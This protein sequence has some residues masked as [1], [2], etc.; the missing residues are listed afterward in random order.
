MLR[1]C[2]VAELSLRSW[3]NIQE[4]KFSPSGRFNVLSGDNGAGKS[5]ILEAIDYLTSLQSF[6]GARTEDL[7]TSG[8]EVSSLSARVEGDTLKHTL[9]IQL[10][11]KGRRSLVL[12][13]KR[14]SS[15]LS[16]KEV[17]PRVVFHPGELRLSSGA[18][19]G[20]RAFLDSILERSDASYASSLSTYQKALRSRNRLL[21]QTPDDLRSIRAYNPILAEHGARIG[22][23]RRL[24]VEELAT[25]AGESFAEIF[26]EGLALGVRYLARVEPT[27]ESMERAL[28][29]SLQKDIA[30]GYTVE[31]PQSDD[32]L[33][34]LEK[35]ASHSEAR[36]QASQ[37]QHRSIALSLKIAELRLLLKRTGKVPI[38]LLDD[39]TSE[40]DR[41]RNK[42]LF[43][44][45]QNL[46]GQVF[47][48]TTHPEFILLTENRRDY[49][50]EEGK[51][52]DED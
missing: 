4:L 41:R 10:P 31:G 22:M 17:F 24:L 25:I 15:L 20:R 3:R 40:L 28:H 2:F 49:T 43:G 36:R 19:D 6:R 48:S 7:V 21:R 12:N 23:A 27:I 52:V 9:R 45:L 14:P 13:E 18:P 8:E 35:G 39:V 51:F 1:K 34:D 5:S 44:L 32:L 37:G 50:I 26:G 47:L 11:R 42:Q 16:W 46:G 33:L 38:V 30:R 29:E